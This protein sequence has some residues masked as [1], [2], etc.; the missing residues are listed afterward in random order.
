MI[1]DPDILPGVLHLIGQYDSPF[2]RRAGIALSHAG[3]GFRHL[4]WSAFGDA[5]RLRAVNPLTRVPTLVLEDGTVLVDSHAILDHIDRRAAVPLRPAAGA[6][7]DAALHCEGLATGLADK[8]V[9]LFYE[10][11]MH[12]EPAQAWMARCREQIAATALALEAEAIARPE[13]FWFGGALSHADIAVACAWRFVREAHP[14]LL[15]EQR[16]LTLV[17]HCA[18]LEHLPVFRA[19]AQPFIPPA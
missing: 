6:V 14:G 15:A 9:A 4:P 11:H 5:R 13:G 16:L 19:I 10:R 17:A 12:A 18:A 7:R 2:V 1:S 8:A 3:I